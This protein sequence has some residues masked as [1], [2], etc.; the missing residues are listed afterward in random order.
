LDDWQQAY[1]IALSVSSRLH[2]AR[3]TLT[4]KNCRARVRLSTKSKRIAASIS[5]ALAPD[6]SRLP[7]GDESD[8]TEICLDGYDV[9]F[10]TKTDDIATLRASINS[11]LRLAD[12]SYRCLM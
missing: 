2:Q 7:K 11:Y 1:G 3:M 4:L 12:T 8:S 10:N 5:A 6:L 9:L